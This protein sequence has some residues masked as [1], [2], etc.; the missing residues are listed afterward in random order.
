MYQKTAGESCFAYSTKLTQIDIPNVEKL[1]KDGL[2]QGYE[3]Y[4]P[5]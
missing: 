1:E 3:I 5:M 2:L 4:R